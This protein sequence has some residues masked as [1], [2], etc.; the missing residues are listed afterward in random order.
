MIRNAIPMRR[1]GFLLFCLLSIQALWVSHAYAGDHPRRVLMLM[2]SNGEL[3]GTGKKTGLWLDTLA[4]PY[5]AFT[6]AGYEVT[7]VSVMGGK[8]PIDPRGQDHKT[9]AVERFEQ[10]KDAMRQL[11]TTL[12]LGQVHADDFDLFFIT[13]GHGL[14][15]DCVDNAYVQGL[16][17]KFANAGKPVVAVDHGVALLAGLQ[18]SDGSSL[19]RGR[20]MAA[21]TREEEAELDLS[22]S[23]PI[24]ADVALEK[25]GV[26]VMRAKAFQPSAVRDGIFITGQNPASTG[27]VTKL[28]LEA[29][30]VKR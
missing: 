6:K 21:P 1:L 7:F 27:K 26:K 25:A 11:D 9:P 14:L 19:I 18:G 23:L 28:A 13:G 30:K 5:Y 12:M 22:A 15:W 10:D 2:T 29:L 4:T 20:R 3:Y 8:P 16:L 17:W 24:Y